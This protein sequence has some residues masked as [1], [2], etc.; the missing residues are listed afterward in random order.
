MSK[1]LANVLVDIELSNISDYDL[2]SELLRRKR[3]SGGSRIPK[4]KL[5]ALLD[6]LDL[7]IEET[8]TGIEIKDK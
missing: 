5:I 2:V 8:K 4:T 7:K 6:T 1:V 3:L